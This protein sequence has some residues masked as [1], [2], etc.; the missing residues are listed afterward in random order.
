[1]SRA[2]ETIKR[3]RHL[4]G[5]GHH[6]ANTT[7]LH[8]LTIPPL[9]QRTPE[10][11]RI[12]TIVNSYYLLNTELLYT[13]TIVQSKIYIILLHLVHPC[14][15]RL[16]IKVKNTEEHSAEITTNQCNI[17]SNRCTRYSNKDLQFSRKSLEI[18]LPRITS[19]TFL[20]KP[21]LKGNM[22]HCLLVHR[23]SVTQRTPSCGLM[24]RQLCG[25]T[26][27]VTGAYWLKSISDVALVKPWLCTDTSTAAVYH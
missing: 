8:L 26:V 12:K 7:I 16:S 18:H 19:E 1:M 3:R 14:I 15:G 2:G 23:A 24:A 10:K 5:P 21:P 13:G 11:E 6:P 25:E 20:G 22:A 9:S 27:R 4:H 17:L